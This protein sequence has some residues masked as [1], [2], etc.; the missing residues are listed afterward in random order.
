MAEL[1][2]KDRIAQH[3]LTYHPL[4]ET[5]ELVARVTSEVTGLDRIVIYRFDGEKLGAIAATTKGS[6]VPR[7]DLAGLDNSRAQGALAGVLASRSIVNAEDGF[8]VV[9]IQRGE[10]VVGII[11]IAHHEE[12]PDDALQSTA[13]F[14]LQAAI[15][16]MNDAQI[17]QDAGQWKGQIAE[18]LKLDNV[19]DIQDLD[20]LA[21]DS[22]R[23]S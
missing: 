12:V 15:A 8:A 17:Q 7:Q 2:G 23:G 9:P 20:R 14:A 6:L 21:D 4:D 1:E 5:L 13:S 11:E 19:L 3:L 18:I 22:R 10:D 16:N